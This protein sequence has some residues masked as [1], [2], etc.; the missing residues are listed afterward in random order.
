MNSPDPNISSKIK[1]RVTKLFLS[2]NNY[3]PPKITQ[4]TITFRQLPN[5]VEPLDKVAL[6]EILRQ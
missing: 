3:I 4:P 5:L 2:Q 6:D 1:K